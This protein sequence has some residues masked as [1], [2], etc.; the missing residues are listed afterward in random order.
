[1]ELCVEVCVDVLVAVVDWLEV[2]VLDE[3]AVSVEV[4]VAEDVEL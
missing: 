1:M 4:C 2:S 3:V